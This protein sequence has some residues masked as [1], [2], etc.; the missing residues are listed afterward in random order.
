M[1]K[2]LWV[3][4]TVAMMATALFLATALAGGEAAQAAFGALATE[5]GVS[6]SGF[7]LARFEDVTWEDG[8]LGTPEPDESCVQGT[9]DGHVVWIAVGSDA[10]R[11]HTDLDGSLL[12]LAAGPFPAAGVGAASLPT[13]ATLREP[14]DVP[15][16][17][18]GPGG[19]RVMLASLRMR[20]A[21]G[22]TF[23]RLSSSLP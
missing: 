21:G 1:M 8:C 19:G 2:R 12:R 10:Y 6:E 7:T 23:Q 17:G 20:R 9:V 11:Y 3:P 16:G 5:L 22:R 13:G 15:Q 18:P 14:P 4:A